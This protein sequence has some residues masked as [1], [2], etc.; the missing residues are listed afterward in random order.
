MR[1][2]FSTFC[3]LVCAIGM[4]VLPIRAT[5]D[6]YR[7][8]PQDKLR[9]KVVEW[10]TDKAEYFDWAVFANEYSVSAS[11]TVSLPL[12]GSL[13]AAGRTT[14]EFATSIA[15]TLQQRAGLSRRP[16][17]TI[18]IVQYRPIY[19]V[20][21][22]QN[23]GEYPYRP[24]LTVLQA[25]GLAGG[26]L[27]QVGMEAGRMEKDRITAQGVHE[28]ARLEA[29]RLL[30][31][32]ARLAAE[33]DG[34]MQIATPE[35]LRND[36]E[37]AR[38]IADE[39]A[40]MNARSEALKSQLL[41]YSEIRSLFSREVEAL[42][43]KIEVQNRQITMARREQQTV[44]ALVAK[45]LAVS[46]REF[47][48]ERTLADLESKLLDYTTAVLRARQEISKAERAAADLKAE[49]KAQIVADKQ[50]TEAQ[51]DQ[52]KARL[53]TSLSLINEA[54]VTMSQFLF[55]KTAARPTTVFSIIRR[56]GGSTVKSV[57][58]ESATIEPGDVV[59]VDQAVGEP[60]S[61]GQSS[62]SA[63]SKD[64]VTR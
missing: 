15:E 8:G 30:V 33:L 25:I 39:T 21:A 41:A 9:I 26:V 38:L 19:V 53:A 1:S 7:L 13:P 23:S 60:A 57:A 18:E 47:G 40:V 4:L 63:A 27:Q 46:S 12:I 6:D 64:S 37:V 36:A 56:V 49:R 54:T 61:S 3:G 44:S 59:Q 20:G 48:L 5:A 29:R 55:D 42:E 14:E 31:R 58:D 62:I 24:G 45:G 35:E 22:V 43:Q 2:K 32:R 17:A 11:G 51:I 16:E 10:R 52:S 28:S 50:D 34:T